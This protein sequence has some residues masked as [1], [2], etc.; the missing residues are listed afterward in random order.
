M[1]GAE[2]GAEDGRPRTQR[3]GGNPSAYPP[4]QRPH[5]P[6]PP[7]QH[8]PLQQTPA[9]QTPA[10][11]TPAQP[12]PAPQTP[13]QQPPAQQTPA[14]QTPAQQTPA[15]QT[16]AQQTP[17]QQPSLQR[18]FEQR[19]QQQRPLEQRRPGPQPQRL[20]DQRPQPQQ[21]PGPP[22]SLTQAPVFHQPPV[23]RPL[24]QEQ[25]PELPALMGAG[26]AAVG[27]PAPALTRPLPFKPDPLGRPADPGRDRGDYGPQVDGKLPLRQRLIYLLLLALGLF[28]TAR[29]GFFWF[30]LARMPRDF[31]RHLNAGEVGLFGALTFV[32][33]HRQLVDMCSWL[34]CTRVEAYRP[35]PPPAPGLGVAFIIA[36]IPIYFLAFVGVL[37]KKRVTFKTTP[38]GGNQSQDLDRLSVFAPHMVIVAL[39]VGGMGVAVLLGH[40]GWVFLAWGTATSVLFSGFVVHL[41]CRRM[42]AATRRWWHTAPWKG[43]RPAAPPWEV[44][45]QP[46]VPPWALQH[47]LAAPDEGDEPAAVRGSAHYA[48]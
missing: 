30:S 20:S 11:Q 28:L 18:L 13:A 41:A 40:T 38:K 16:P 14:Q 31:G 44:H 29:F 32:V 34:I 26:S 10:Q 37:R 17:A 46:A 9:Q 19:A 22:R 6:P 45:H 43:R 36:A 48:A 42:A 5:A 15:Q 7:V 4:A 35:A 33:W 3:A 27:C 47:R 25:Q 8:P 39:L 1:R 23:R 12:T 24:P 2:R 21:R